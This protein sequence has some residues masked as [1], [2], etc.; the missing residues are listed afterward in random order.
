MITKRDRTQERKEKQAGAVLR[1]TLPYTKI[2]S[3]LWSTRIT[4]R[5][6]VSQQE[7]A[8]KVGVTRKA[9]H[10]IETGKSWP[11]L[12]TALRIANALDKQVEELF[13]LK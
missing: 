1:T 7:L 12:L 5:T 13:T 8:A 2:H 3:K 6:P 4:L 10:N 9:I 11:S